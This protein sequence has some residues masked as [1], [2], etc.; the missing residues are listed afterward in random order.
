VKKSLYFLPLALLVL[1]CSD[2][3]KVTNPTPVKEIWPLKVGNQ[4]TYEDQV[5]DS[6]GQALQLDTTVWLISKDTV[7]E[8]KTWYILTING[9]REPEVLPGANRNDGAWAWDGSSEYLFWRYPAA[10]G[11]TWIVMTD[12]ATVESVN[13]TVA[14]PAGTFVCV[15][16]KWVGDRDRD[17]NYQCHYLSPGVGRVKTEEFFRTA[18]GFE[19]VRFRNELISYALR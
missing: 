5:L 3:N 17:R 12:T 9:V 8:G 18:G 13:S 2:D 6:A 7:I 1:G 14:V 19:Y 16:Y 10:V 11:D 4:W 15:K